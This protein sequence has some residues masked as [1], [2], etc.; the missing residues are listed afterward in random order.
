VSQP[1]MLALCTWLA[2]IFEDQAPRSLAARVSSILLTRLMGANVAAVI[3]ETAET[4]RQ[5]FLA[6]FD[7]FI[8]S[9][10]GRIGRCSRRVLA[11]LGFGVCLAASMVPA[12]AVEQRET[13]TLRVAVY[14]VPPYGY[15]DTDG[16]M[17]GVSVDLWRRV[18][19]QM[20]MAVSVDPGFRYGVDSQRSGAGPFRRRDRRHH[21][22]AGKGGARRLF[23]SRP[24]V[25]GGDRLAK[26]NRAAFRACVLWS[27]SSAL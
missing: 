8:D 22:Y 23:L 17:S 16:S 15:V 1:R 9:R 5:Q 21:D 4:I 11:G 2:T 14:D 25:R 27:P 20:G 7:R 12:F 3:P 10:G 18:A 26:G 24:S 13:E 6:A 19:E